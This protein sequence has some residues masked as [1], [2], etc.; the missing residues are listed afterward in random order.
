MGKPAPWAYIPCREIF[1]QA[2]GTDPPW[3]NPRKASRPPSLIISKIN[4]KK[5]LNSVPEDSKFLNYSKEYE[6]RD[7]ESLEAVIEYLF[8]QVIGLKE[9]AFDKALEEVYDAA[10]QLE[11]QPVRKD[12]NLN[13]RR[14]RPLGRK[15]STMKLTADDKKMLLEWGHPE[16]DFQQIEKAFQKSKTKYML[17]S[18]PISREEAISLLGQK[19]YLSG[20]ARSAF[21]Y[22]AVGE[23]PDGQIVYFDSS[24]LFRDIAPANSFTKKTLKSALS[25]Q[26]Q[27]ASARTADSHASLDS[28]VKNRDPER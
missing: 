18:M 1:V 6:F 26:I 28:S 4:V 15:E 24:N 3:Q 22:T 27:S 2:K 13:K 12:E 25:E 19:Q 10:Q 5:T 17:G 11:Q 7:F 9:K 20:I 8:S 21:H 16:S 14:D 23:T